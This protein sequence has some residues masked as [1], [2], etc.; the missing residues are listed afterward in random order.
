MFLSK[1]NRASLLVRDEQ[2]EGGEEGPEDNKVV[3]K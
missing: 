3:E 1:N 2:F